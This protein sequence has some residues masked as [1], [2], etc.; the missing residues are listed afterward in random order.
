MSGQAQI[1]A[2]TLDRNQTQVL[3]IHNLK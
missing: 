3:K 1:G 2:Q